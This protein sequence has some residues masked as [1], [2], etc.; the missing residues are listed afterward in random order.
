VSLKISRR[1]LYMSERS[2]SEFARDIEE[3]VKR[4]SSYTTGLKSSPI[5]CR[6]LWTRSRDTWT[7]KLAND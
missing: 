3:A 4:I 5:T 1:T 6:K 7:K 2:D